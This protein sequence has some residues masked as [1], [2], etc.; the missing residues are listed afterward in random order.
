MSK[1]YMDQILA[2]LASE[3]PKEY[4][5]DPEALKNMIGKI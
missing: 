2:W 4:Y 3:C 1:E 5:S